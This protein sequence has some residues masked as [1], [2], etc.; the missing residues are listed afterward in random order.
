MRILISSHRYAPDVGGIETVSALL[1]QQWQR[2]GHA[3]TVVTDSVATPDTF[4]AQPEVVRRPSR[5]VL[6]RLIRECDL[7]WHNNISLNTAWPLFLLKKPW[8][9]TTQTWLHNLTG[10]AGIREWLKRLG[11]RRA[12]N[13]YI[14]RSVA[15]HV[16]LPGEVIPNPY[17]A[18][19]FRRIPAIQ[20]GRELVFV[21]RLVSDK[22]VDLLLQALRL[23]RPELQPRLTIIGGG[24]EERAL[25]AMAAD[26]ELQSQVS[27]A[28]VLSGVPLARALNAHRVLVV[29][30][31][32][33]E[34]FGIVALEG[35]AC[36][37]RVVAS[38]GGGLPDAVGP[39]G[40][41]V[42]NGDTGALAR[43]IREEL[44]RND[45]A[46]REDL[47][48]VEHVASHEPERIAQRYLEVFRAA[49][50]T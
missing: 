37:C 1:A 35:L 34:P 7:C 3:V 43:A 9:V 42:P 23:L 18:A 29:P 44:A 11:L 12:R 13:V 47:R 30:S 31:R 25:R 4:V 22:G 8:V 36:G 2:L 28:G 41:L 49:A 6:R 27:F 21:G 39:G 24:P 16:G 26:L 50:A 33:N 45:G 19:L 17:D 46:T 10:R 5:D 14:S 38:N 15:T 20:R 32:W 40:R 48:V